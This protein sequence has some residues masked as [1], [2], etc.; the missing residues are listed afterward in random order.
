MLKRKTL[1]M[2]WY[3]E[4]TQSINKKTDKTALIFKIVASLNKILEEDQQQKQP[5]FLSINEQFLLKLV[6]GIVK[7]PQKSYIIGIT[8]ESASGKTTLVNNAAKAL[9]KDKRKNLFTTVS[10]DNYYIDSS[11]ELKKAGSYENLFMTGFSFDT[12]DAL[13]LELMKAHLTSLKNGCS[14]KTPQYNFVTCE[15]IADQNEKNP[16]LIILNEG[17]FVLNPAVA[18]VDDIKI[19]VFTPFSIIRERWYARAASRGK[20]GN[21]A[22]LQFENVN[23]AA[24]VYIRPTMQNADIV[25]NGLTTAEYIEEMTEK[26]MNMVENILSEL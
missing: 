10:C 16:A 15:S 9:L 12:P 3:M 13:N 11:E 20:T 8:G 24:Q 21:A 23:S 6:T 26:I 7:N 2:E 1:V 17:L 19:Y 14:V 18:D 4:E 22:D 5:L 25:I